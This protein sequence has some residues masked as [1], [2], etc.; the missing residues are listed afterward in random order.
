MKY[1]L[2]NSGAFSLSV[3]QIGGLVKTSKSEKNPN[4]QLYLNPVTYSIREGNKRP[5]LKT[6]THPGFILSFNPCRPKSRGEINI[7]SPNIYDEPKINYNY[8]TD[9]ADLDDIIKGARLIEQMEK[10]EAIKSLLLE[11]PNTSLSSMNDNEIIDDFKER[12]ST[13]Y[14]PS[15]TCRMGNDP[16]SSVVDKNLLVHGINGLR[17][18]D[19]SIFPNITSAN[20]NAPTIMVAHKAS[21][22]INSR[23]N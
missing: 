7:I 17:V 3:N 4:I 10:T 23:L 18:V 12:A 5:L 2:F 20:T 11:K 14:H 6:D 8:L 21:E 15:C 19:A 22:M 9:K 13:I 16:K 1:V